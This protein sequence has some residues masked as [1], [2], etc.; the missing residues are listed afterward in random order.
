LE[1]EF[2]AALLEE[3]RTAG[4]LLPDDVSGMEAEESAVSEEQDFFNEPDT[5]A[6]PD[7]DPDA[8]LFMD[9]GNEP[10]LSY[11]NPTRE[12][13][14]GGVVL[15][16][17]GQ[18]ER[19]HGFTVTADESRA[20][21]NLA[22]DVTIAAAENVRDLLLDLMQEHAAIELDMRE[23]QSTDISFIQLL[24]AASRFAA[25][26]GVQLTLRGGHAGAAGETFSQ[27][28]LSD[29]VRARLSLSSVFVA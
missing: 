11:L 20:V 28:G 3:A 5:A 27:C 4:I 6:D 23:T 8:D 17:E 14:E 22:G 24:I 12:E 2:E 29:E 16:M 26:H 1:A 9:S 18:T 21:V 25:E 7:A 19:L 15:A 10:D 13:V